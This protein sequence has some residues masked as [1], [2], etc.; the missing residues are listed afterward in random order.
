MTQVACL[1]N[2]H[3]P[4]RAQKAGLF[5]IKT[6]S[7]HNMRGQSERE[8]YIKPVFLASNSLFNQTNPGASTI[9]GEG[10]CRPY[11]FDRCR[12]PTKALYMSYL[13]FNSCSQN[14]GSRD[15]FSQR[16]G[17]YMSRLTKHP[18]F[19]LFTTIAYARLGLGAPAL[20]FAPERT[21]LG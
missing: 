10:A 9:G 19:S 13:F 8:Q 16:K 1:Q 2:L 17:S 21:T 12:P 14:P 7:T 15:L 11:S 5:G 18:T 6:D 20:R 3:F 4:H